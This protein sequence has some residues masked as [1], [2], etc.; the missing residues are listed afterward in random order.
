M[1]IN[2]KSLKVFELIE[3]SRKV[4]KWDVRSG[5]SFR[6]MGLAW[7]NN[8]TK[9]ALCAASEARCSPSKSGS[10]ERCSSC[11]GHTRRQC[12]K[13]GGRKDILN[14]TTTCYILHCLMYYLCT[15][16]QSVWSRGPE[17]EWSEVWGLESGVSR[18]QFQHSR[19]RYVTSDFFRS[20]NGSLY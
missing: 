17:S 16:V 7:C 9:A 12:F 10:T 15:T 6:W 19:N 2:S 18:Y 13:V 20:S 11:F 8:E 1:V 14:S 4:C 3:R 5:T